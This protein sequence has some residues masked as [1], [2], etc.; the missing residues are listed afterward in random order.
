[1]KKYICLN[2]EYEFDKPVDGFY[3]P[4]YGLPMPEDVC[5]NCGSVAIWEND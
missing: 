1:M 4:D 2:C 5:P 3:Y